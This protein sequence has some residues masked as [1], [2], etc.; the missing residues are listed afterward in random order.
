MLFPT[1][2]FGLFFLV[3][4]AVAWG[5]QASNEWRK[6]LLLLA[7]WTFYGAWDWRFVALLIGSAFLNW[8]A[9]RLIDAQPEEETG[10]RKAI[11]IVGVVANLAILGF[12]KYYGF[13]LE[14]LGDVLGA[15]GIQRDLPLMQV[16]LP[17]GIS[18]FTFQGMSYLADVHARRLA[19][20]ALL[21]VT[22]LMS[23]FP[24]LVAGPIVRGSDLLPQ[25]ARAPRLTRDMATMGLLLIVWGL[26]K[27]AVIA[28][29]LSTQLVDPVFFDPS[30]HSRADL[31]AAAY[32]YAIQI[33]CDFSAY[34]DMAIGIA[35]LLGYR[36]PLNFDQPYRAAS[37]QEFW[38]RWHISLSSWLRDYL[39]I[40]ALG[41]NRRGFARQCVNLVATMLLGGLWHGAKWTFVV[42]GGL[43]GGVLALERIWDRYRPEDWPRL[44][45]VVTL[46]VT[47]HVVLIGWIFFRS[48][49]FGG[50]TTYL[51]GMAASNATSAVLTP[52]MLVLILFGLAIHFTPPLLAQNVALRLR[53]L[54]AP[55]LG[56]LTGAAILVVDA[57][58]FEGVAPFIYYQF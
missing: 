16:V 22:L 3:V 30:A 28:S 15:L 1:L 13:F 32:G 29:E 39:Y 24:H 10:R 18:F 48:E 49:T 51:G 20:A 36:F 26:F 45:R 8:G 43:H 52:L 41:G 50:A 4:Y 33:Y 23:F 17:V 11:L 19:P 31:I 35:A 21:D 44:P 2:S 7:S 40:G 27:K 58:R 37:L 6:I 14:Q 12:F 53:R 9:A 46:L 54:P 57:M 56:L 5:A 55:A 38:R 47:F 42:W 34:S 25:F